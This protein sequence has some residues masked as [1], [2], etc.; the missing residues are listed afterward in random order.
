M[1][2]IL[3]SGPAGASKSAVARQII[4]DDPGL[5]VQ[6]DFQQIHV[7]LSGAVRDPSTGLY[8]VRD[9]RLNP[10]TEYVRRAVITG[11]LARDIRVLVTNSD[12]A[13]A[14][15]RSLL[16][17]LGPGATERIVDPGIDVVQARLSDPVSGELSDE[18]GRAVN[19]WYGRLD[20]G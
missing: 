4:E 18:C 9:G 11:A 10:I 16:D 5:I 3:L 7:A 2:G 20:R 15:R 6:A 8:P 13:P 12:G 19:R 17:L 14:R 1:P